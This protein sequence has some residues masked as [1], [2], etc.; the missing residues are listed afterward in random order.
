MITVN[1][2]KFVDA[3]RKADA[4]KLPDMSKG[5][6]YL[7]VNI[8]SCL[9]S[10]EEVRLSNINFNAFELEDLEIFNSLFTDVLET[11]YY[12]ANDIIS[13]LR[14]AAPACKAVLYV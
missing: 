3:V 6:G 7:F 12:A 4:F 11:N 2:K 10:G 14:E 9:S 13:A 1:T 5:T 8:Y